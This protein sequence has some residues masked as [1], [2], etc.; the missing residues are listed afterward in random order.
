MAGSRLD[1]AKLVTDRA[2][3]VGR[4][5]VLRQIEGWADCVSDE[6]GRLAAIGPRGRGKSSILMCACAM[7]RSRDIPVAMVSAS[8]D[9]GAR[10]LVRAILDAAVVGLDEAGRLA[11]EQ[12]T[13]WRE[14]VAGQTVPAD[15]HFLLSR[16]LD[17][18]PITQA[19]LQR[20]LVLL[21]EA[22]GSL[23]IVIDDLDC[24]AFAEPEA[25]AFASAVAA[26]GAAVLVGATTRDN[27]P[28]A[29]ASTFVP[30]PLRRLEEFEVRRMLDLGPSPDTTSALRRSEL[31]VLAYAAR[32]EPRTVAVLGRYAEDM[33][34]KTGDPPQLGRRVLQQAA[35]W[36]EWHA[37]GEAEKARW[38][39][40][41]ELLEIVDTLDRP[42]GHAARQIAVLGD[43]SVG[44]MERLHA[45]RERFGSGSSG[46]TGPEIAAMVG[47]LEE[48]GLAR[49]VDGRIELC[50]GNRFAR[51]Y[52]A[53][54]TR[55]A[56][57]WG[58]GTSY[59]RAA[60]AEVVEALAAAVLG[61]EAWEAAAWRDFLSGSD[62]L[63]KEGGLALVQGLLDRGDAAEILGSGMLVPTG[64]DDVDA[65]D[66]VALSIGLAVTLAEDGPVMA[67]ILQCELRRTRVSITD[68]RDRLGSW[69]GEHQAWLEQH[70]LRLYDVAIRSLDL[71][72]Q[73][74]L[75]AAV[76]PG[77]EHAMAKYSV[78]SGEI[79]EAL[80]AYQEIRALPSAAKRECPWLLTGE[81]GM[82]SRIGFFCCIAGNAEQALEAIAS[83][84]GLTGDGDNFAGLEHVL[85]RYN[86]SYAL[87][88]QRLWAK[89]DGEM[90]LAEKAL[91]DVA[92]A[93]VLL[94]LRLVTPAEYKPPSPTWHVAAVDAE[95]LEDVLRAQRNVYQAHAGLLA[96]DEYCELCGSFE[97]NASV[98]RLFAWTALTRYGRID[99]AE[100]LLSDARCDGDAECV[101]ELD[102]IRE[103]A[104]ELGGEASP[105]A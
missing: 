54:G 101:R 42:T 64:L 14:Q 51:A 93:D 86:A 99:V 17:A 73:R 72:L 45:L 52:M 36:L 37:I 13:R 91:G 68:C 82:L 56:D 88:L 75:A 89:A 58:F 8:S 98:A 105:A 90:A 41:I 31:R 78:E 85:L 97:I 29:L 65:G 10:T 20:D 76:T 60:N 43:M 102:W 39:R 18:G 46:L 11:G 83:A 35:R 24:V 61:D 100:E 59:S 67:K 25:L 92:T 103:L 32:G 16:E 3:L 9:M 21:R 12:G 87:S 66:L 6:P 74:V 28:F 33:A 50:D 19:P 49:D 5:Q 71:G 63:D 84:E 7:L 48:A 104:R 53:S 30:M 80:E 23:A 81:R 94:V 79:E 57:L 27:L 26:S 38:I 95:E 15:E 47:A 1:P 40:T 4:S 34:K 70:Q 22:G 2:D 62:E 44:E 55:P 77:G 69:L 96:E